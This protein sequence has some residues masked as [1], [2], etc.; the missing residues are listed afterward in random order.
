VN[1]KTRVKRLEGRVK[2]PN[3]PVHVVFQRI[4]ESDEKVVSHIRAENHA[5]EAMLIVVK[6]VDVS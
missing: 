2:S 3:M 1:L 5:P 4:G 6:F